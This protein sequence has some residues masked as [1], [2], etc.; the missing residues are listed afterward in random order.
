MLC[1][2]KCFEI[3]FAINTINA[4]VHDCQILMFYSNLIWVSTVCSDIL[5]ANSGFKSNSSKLHVCT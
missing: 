2:C 4:K 1:I 5:P 3:N